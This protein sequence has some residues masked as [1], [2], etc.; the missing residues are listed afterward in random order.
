MKSSMSIPGVFPP[1]K[2]NGRLLVDGGTTTNLPV[3]VA[4]A[5]GAERVVAV[6]LASPEKKRDWETS[7]SMLAILNAY[8]EREIKNHEL[9]QADFVLRPVKKSIDTLDFSSCLD[10]MEEAYENTLESDLSGV[11]KT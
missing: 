7:N 3:S 1:T 8:K 9:S 10:S 4:R 6:D 5:L 2:S 11:L